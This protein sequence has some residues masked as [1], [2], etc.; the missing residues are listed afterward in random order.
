MA[1][2]YLAN[3]LS[4][5]WLNHLGFGF[6]IS[7]NQCGQINRQRI[8]ECSWSSVSCKDLCTEPRPIAVGISTEQYSVAA[9]ANLFSSSILF[10]LVSLTLGNLSHTSRCIPLDLLPLSGP[11]CLLSFSLP[12]TFSLFPR[13]GASLCPSLSLT[14][15]SLAACYWFPFHSDRLNRQNWK[16][17]F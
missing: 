14:F 10:N 9:G 3:L 16:Y 1:V 15:L 12:S 11:K 6:P 2:K 17:I 13:D 7:C 4:L 5:S 8:S